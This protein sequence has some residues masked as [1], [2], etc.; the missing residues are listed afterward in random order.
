M[1][2]KSC[3]ISPSDR[4]REWKH[5]C[6]WWIGIIRI[7]RI[8]CQNLKYIIYIKYSSHKTQLGRR[9]IKFRF[10]N[11]RIRKQKKKKKSIIGKRK[12]KWIISYFRKKIKKTHKLSYNNQWLKY[13]SKTQ[14]NIRVVLYNSD[15][16]HIT[17][18]L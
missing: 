9:K 11:L 7:F 4:K 16:H 18:H 8:T 1:P 14:R 17:I 15:Y 5:K 2:N 13:L 6:F 12:R 3:L 10:L